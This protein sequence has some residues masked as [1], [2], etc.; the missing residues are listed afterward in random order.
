MQ[1][2]HERG[3]RTSSLLEWNSANKTFFI[4]LVTGVIYLAY[5]LW[6]HAMVDHPATKGLIN[7]QGLAATLRWLDHILVIT[8][9]LLVVI[10]AV[11][12]RHRESIWLE[13]L[14]AQFYSLSLSMIGYF[15]GTLALSTGVVLAGAPVFGFMFLRRCPVLAALAVA[16]S[17]QAGLTLAQVQGHLPYAP[18]VQSL[19][20]ADGSLSGFWVATFYLFALPHFIVLTTLSWFI[21][22]RWRQREDE[23]RQLSLMDSLTGLANRRAIEAHLRRETEHGQRQRLPVSVLMVD[24]DHFKEL[25]DTWGH[26]VG[27]QALSRIGQTLSNALRQSDQIGRYGGEEFLLVLNGTNCNGA[28]ILAERLRSAV[29]NTDIAVTAESTRTLSASFG[30]FCCEAADTVSPDDMVRLA[31]EALYE[32]KARGRNQVVL[33]HPLQGAEAATA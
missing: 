20:R 32:A 25:N 1:G 12:A 22:T 4:L 7:P 9:L 3:R 28:R 27:D 21:L 33:A 26:R 15:S 8:G 14:G 5:S 11:P 24:L 2:Q 31:D 16:M 18:M 17:L 6:G 30:I 19:T 10:L 23:A 29:N 13:H